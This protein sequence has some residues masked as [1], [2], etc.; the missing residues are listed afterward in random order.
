[1]GTTRRSPCHS[2]VL[3]HVTD[4]PA[5]VWHNRDEETRDTSGHWPPSLPFLGSCFS[6]GLNIDSTSVSPACSPLLGHPCDCPHS[7]PLC[8]KEAGQAVVLL[9]MDKCISPHPQTLFLPRVRLFFAHIEGVGL[10]EETSVSGGFIFFYIKHLSAPLYFKLLIWELCHPTAGKVLFWFGFF[11]E[12][13]PA[14]SVGCTAVLGSSQ[15]VPSG[16]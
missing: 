4:A 8:R 15:Q 11:T 9:C 7:P 1:M 12:R 5:W 16:A 2:K 3:A 14:S 10:G 13:V 6:S